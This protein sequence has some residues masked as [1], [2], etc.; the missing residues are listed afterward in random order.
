M[1]D[2]GAGLQ[3]NNVSIPGNLKFLISAGSQIPSEVP[4]VKPVVIPADLGAQLRVTPDR[5]AANSAGTELTFTLFIKNLDKGKA[6][7]PYVILPI[8]PNLEV[9]NTNFTDSR[10]W[11]NN[12][13]T[14]GTNPH[15]EIRFHDLEQGQIATASVT[16]KVKAGVASGA[17][18]SQR[19][20]V[21]WDDDVAAARS[22]QSNSIRVVLSDNNTDQSAGKIQQFNPANPTVIKGSP[23]PASADFFAPGEKVSLWYTDKNGQSTSL[24]Y[25]WADM[26]GKINFN[27]KTAGLEPGSYA[28]SGQGDHS[29][30]FASDKST[31]SGQM[32]VMV[33]EGMQQFTKDD[34]VVT[35]ANVTQYK[36]NFF[37]AGERVDLWLSGPDGKSTSMGYLWAD[38][39]G[40][41]SFPVSI[42]GMAAGNYTVGAFGSTSKVTAKTLLSIAF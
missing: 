30:F 13:V 12:V 7:L 38:Q 17:V 23:I 20:T 37:S 25:Q 36:G 21:R 26:S 4:I 27:F 10:D 35:G 31:V 33:N 29:G 1:I 14:D 15:L 8:D 34:A 39:N 18:V 5:L 28:I 41:V 22:H 42:A 9:V 3:W 19:F 32:I 40:C 2:N 16:F 24:G 6:K 11:V